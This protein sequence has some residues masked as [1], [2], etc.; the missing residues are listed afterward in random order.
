MIKTC[1]IKTEKIDEGNKHIANRIYDKIKKQEKQKN[2][3]RQNRKCP[4]D[5]G[6]LII[7]K[8]EKKGK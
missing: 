6:I 3:K 2:H 7:K 4:R 5:G 8:E 1:M